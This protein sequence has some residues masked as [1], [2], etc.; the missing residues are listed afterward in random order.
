MLRELINHAKANYRH[1]WA[2]RSS[3]AAA[4]AAVNFFLVTRSSAA[5]P[6]SLDVDLLAHE[7]LRA[8]QELT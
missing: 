4:Q 5:A 2:T 7:D 6:E 1:F 8:L 3:P